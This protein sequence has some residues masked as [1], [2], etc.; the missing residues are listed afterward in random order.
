MVNDSIRRVASGPG[1]LTPEAVLAKLAG[2]VFAAVAVGGVG[3]VVGG[4]L[5]AVRNVVGGDP[6]A[7]AG[8]RFVAPPAEEPNTR[9][10][11]LCRARVDTVAIEHVGACGY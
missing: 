4:A 9:G 1:R 6:A 8:E 5:A 7:L 3:V 10:R 2:T 11:E